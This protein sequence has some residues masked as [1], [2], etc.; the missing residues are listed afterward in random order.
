MEDLLKRG[1][2]MLETGVRAASDNRRPFSSRAW[3]K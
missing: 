3:E 1:Y 2:I